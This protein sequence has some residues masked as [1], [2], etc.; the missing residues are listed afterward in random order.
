MSAEEWWELAFCLL[1]A[2]VWALFLTAFR[3]GK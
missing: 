1:I 2:I 3:S